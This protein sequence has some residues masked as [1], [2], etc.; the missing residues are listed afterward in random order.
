MVHRHQ[1]DDLAQ[2]FDPPLTL[3]GPGMTHWGTDGGSPWLD[4]FFGNLSDA[5]AARIAF[6][7]Q[8][9]CRLPLFIVLRGSGSYHSLR[10]SPAYLVLRH[11]YGCGWR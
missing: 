1:L 8:R 6:L 4:Q 9:E 10:C 2:S 5:R 3:V 11:K 7:A